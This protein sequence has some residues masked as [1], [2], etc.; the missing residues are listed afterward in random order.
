MEPKEWYQ[1]SYTRN[2]VRWFTVTDDIGMP[3]RFFDIAAAEQEQVNQIR[4]R[5]YPARDTM[6]VRITESYF[7]DLSDRQVYCNWDYA[8]MLV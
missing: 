1:V 6:V 8:V 4:K 5:F 3:K 7:S 2:C